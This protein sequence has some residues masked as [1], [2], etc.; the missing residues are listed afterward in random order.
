MV[1]VES[2][3]PARLRDP[4]GCALMEQLALPGLTLADAAR[5]EDFW[6]GPNAD[7]LAAVARLANDASEPIA[8]VHGPR[9]AGKTHLL[10]AAW[11]RAREGGRRAGYLPLEEA[12]M[13]DPCL[14]EGWGKLDFAAFD[15][16][17][18]IAG[19]GVWERA[20]FRI[21]EELRERGATLLAA[22]P[23]P[24]D[25]LGLE[26]SDLASRLAWGPVYALQPLDDAQL[27]ALAVHLADARGLDLPARAAAWLV[28]R[29]TRDSRSV[30]R[31]IE[32]LDR[33]SLAAKRRLS[34]PFLREVLADEGR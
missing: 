3:S 1:R 13:L 2:G 33:A 6:P 25:A 17:E 9:A 14:V 10:K 11:R 7:V 19:F 12:V 31:T 23:A 20:L 27:A 26:L 29:V 18:C 8:F 24:P 30:A 21:A 16:L 34:I 28:T 15:A 5:L 32:R 4:G 22:G